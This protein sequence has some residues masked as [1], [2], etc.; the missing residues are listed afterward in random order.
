MVSRPAGVLNKIGFRRDVKLFLAVL[1]GFL[2]TL[3][4]VLLLLLQSNVSQMRE[5]LAARQ[6][7][8]AEAAML[9]IRRMPAHSDL[10]AQ[11]AAIRTRYGFA[12]IEYVAGNRPPIQSGHPGEPLDVIEKRFPNGAV[13][14]HSD[15][16]PFESIRRRFL[17]SAVI[18]LVATSIGIALLMLYLPRILRPVEAMLDDARA[19]GERDHDTDEVSYLIDTFRGS[20]AT[21]KRQEAELKTL[22][23]R[24]K[25]RAD[26]LQTITSTL[27]RSLTSGFVAIGPA[28]RLLEM[29]SAAREIL[30]LANDL[31]VA[32]ERIERV[33]GKNRFADVVNDAIGQRKALSR[34]EIEHLAH[35]QPKT[36][37]LTIVPLFNN[38][39]AFLGTLVLFT[40]LTDVRR[41]EQRVRDMQALAD[42]GEMSAGIAH[43]FRNALSTIHGY[44]RLAQRQGSIDEVLARVQRADQEA[45]ALGAAIESLLNF[46]RPMTV[47]VRPVDV[48]ELSAHVVERLEAH[49][50]G[51]VI[52]IHGTAVVEGDPSLLER[53]IE[54][55]I[56][57]AIDAIRESG[58]KGRIEIMASA[59]P[60]TL[61]IRDNGAGFETETAGRLLLPFQSRK[62]A[63][64]GLGLPLARKIALLHGGSLSLSGRAGEGAIVRFEFPPAGSQPSGREAKI[65]ER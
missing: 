44:L 46:A 32:G 17:F 3:V 61:T 39:G 28:D 43:E 50:R 64:L 6:N 34:E 47:D 13:R 25:V 58:R 35:G 4:V 22:H 20:I 12:A 33:I 11:L 62:P 15:N 65:S 63:G 59:D 9:D 55:I 10:E 48:A 18:S 41:L 60:P 2:A 54:N 40:D 21:L 1:V 7:N 42:L 52:D 14:F 45:A 26:D 8:L 23:E 36:I 24:E 19:L 51:I 30:G 49:T 27:T 31:P 38:A 5:I 57:N 56:R 16:S 29:N 53:A 37:G